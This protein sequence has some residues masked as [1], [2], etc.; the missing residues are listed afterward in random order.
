MGSDMWVG[1][2]FHHNGCCY[3]AHTFDFFAGDGHGKAIN[4]SH[5][6]KTH[7]HCWDL[8]STLPRVSY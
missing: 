8:G 4:S 5:N 6:R 7:D 3:L 1:D 2:D